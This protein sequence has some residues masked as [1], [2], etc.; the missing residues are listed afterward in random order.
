MIFYLVAVNVPC[1]SGSDF[2]QKKERIATSGA[3]ALLSAT[4]INQE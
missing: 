4:V 2:H 3:I 1:R